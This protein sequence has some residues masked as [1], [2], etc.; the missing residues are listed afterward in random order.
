MYICELMFL[1]KN[2]KGGKQTLRER[3]DWRRY[4]KREKGRRGRWRGQGWGREERNDNIFLIDE[5]KIS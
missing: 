3:R 2:K 1:T 4:G 5:E